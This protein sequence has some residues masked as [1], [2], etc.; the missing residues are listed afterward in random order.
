MHKNSQLKDL[1]LNLS[2]LIAPV[3][4]CLTVQNNGNI[5]EVILATNATVEGQATAHYLVEATNHLPVQMTR[6]APGVPQGGELEYV[7]SHTL[8]Q[9][10]HN[11]MRMK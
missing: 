11:R 8:S 9:A 10:V 2:G 7:D 4:M 1:S 5:S 3:M 6:I